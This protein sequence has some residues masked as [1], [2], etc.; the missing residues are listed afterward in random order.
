MYAMMGVTG[1]VGGAAARSL[2]QAG[3]KVRAVLR[4]QSKAEPWGALGAEIAIATVE[5]VAAL[6]KAFSGT[7]GVFVMVPPN[8][9][10]DPDFTS[11]RL[12][13]KNQTEALAASGALKV[14]ALSSVGGERESGFGLITQVHILEE[15]LS[16]LSIPTGIMRPCWFMEN[17]LWDIAP[18]R[19]TGEMASFLHPLDKPYPMVATADIGRVAAET[20]TQSWTGRRV[21]EIEGPKPYSQNEIAALLGKALGRNVAACLI[22][23]DEWAARFQA[24]GT[25][26]PDPR[27]EMLDGFNSG[28]IA[29]D[30]GKNEH[31]I[32]KTFYEDALAELVK[33]VA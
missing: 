4:D 11:A 19:Q 30:P 29:F 18:A 14:V 24:Q 2:L 27:I 33:L 8:F 15:A 25:A 5:D 16:T 12:A 23:R 10:P 32:G 20:L 3:H 31:V 21:I 6:T 26:W 13:A 9:A 28:W 17:A 22:P 1:N 7:E